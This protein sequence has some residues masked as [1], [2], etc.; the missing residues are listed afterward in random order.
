MADFENSDHG[1]PGWIQYSDRSIRAGAVGL[2]DM[3]T[4]PACVP[5]MNA[6][7]IAII[8]GGEALRA[9][10]TETCKLADEW[11]RAVQLALAAYR[12]TEGAKP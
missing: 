2:L 6:A 10:A 7:I 11:N 8:A 5:D 4:E 9:S 3:P 1:K 12:A